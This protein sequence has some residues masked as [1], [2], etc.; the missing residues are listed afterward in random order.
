ML[1]LATEN[2]D[3]REF[4]E[5]ELEK[6]VKFN[7]SDKTFDEIERK[8][9][10]LSRKYDYYGISTISCTIFRDGLICYNQRKF[11]EGFDII[12]IYYDVM[13]DLDGRRCGDTEDRQ[14]IHIKTL[15][16][17][18]DIFHKMKYEENITMDD[19]RSLRY[20]DFALIEQLH[21]ICR[22]AIDA[23]EDINCKAFY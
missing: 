15:L 10:T 18:K 2:N 13:Y 4:Y 20:Y 1:F 5:K 6:V 23:N 3:I 19:L 22:Y 21:N 14:E 12:F 8:I 16:F 11:S 17:N 7:V 9:E